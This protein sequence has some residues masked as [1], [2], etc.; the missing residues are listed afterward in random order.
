[1][2][3]TTYKATL[4]QTMKNHDDYDIEGLSTIHRAKPIHNMAVGEYFNVYYGESSKNGAKWLGDLESS[5]RQFALT[6]K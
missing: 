4:I 3:T 2:N 5:L 6:I 1:M